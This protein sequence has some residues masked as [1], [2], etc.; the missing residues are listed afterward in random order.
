MLDVGVGI[1]GPACL[2][3]TIHGADRVTGIDVENPLLKRAAATVAS[4]GLEDQ[5]NLELVSPGP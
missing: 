3:V 2:L 5:I 4:Y 1:G